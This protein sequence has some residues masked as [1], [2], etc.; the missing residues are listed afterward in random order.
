MLSTDR[1][2]AEQALDGI[3][4]WAVT[5]ACFGPERNGMKWLMERIEKHG[6]VLPDDP[7]LPPTVF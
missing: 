4:K 2:E 3:A 7:S 6:Q 1:T 5:G